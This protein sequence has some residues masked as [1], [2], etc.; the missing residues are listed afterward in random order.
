MEE[1]QTLQPSQGSQQATE[2]DGRGHR[3]RGFAVATVA[4]CAGLTVLAVAATLAAGDARRD[5]GAGATVLSRTLHDP[6]PLRTLSAFGEGEAVDLADHVGRPMVVNFWATWCAPCTREM[7]LLRDMSRE[8]G[9]DVT[10]LGVNVQ[11]KPDAAQRFVRRARIGYVQAADPKAE[12]FGSV[13][14]VGMPT[15]L[16]VDQDGIVRHRHTGE[17][18]RA[19]L[20]RLLRQH[21]GVL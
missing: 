6:L 17:L 8:L 4:V 10:F 11:D 3:R 15:T 14:A 2:A 12:F 19:A 9:G 5:A 13:D 20:R 1:H 18:D 7:P 21:L 16:F